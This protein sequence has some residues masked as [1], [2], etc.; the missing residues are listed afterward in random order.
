MKNIII[1]N[2]RVLGKQE[3]TFL[4]AI[5]MGKDIVLS[6]EDQFKFTRKFGKSDF[7]NKN[8]IANY[9]H[10]DP[11]V[12]IELLGPD[13]AKGGMGAGLSFQGFEHC[14]NVYR[15][16]YKHKKI[17]DLFCKVG[18]PGLMK[19]ITLNLSD[20]LAGKSKPRHSWA[21][22]GMLGSFSFGYSI[23][24][25]S[26]IDIPVE[27]IKISDAVN[28]DDISWFEYFIDES[29]KTPKRGLKGAIDELEMNLNNKKLKMQPPTSIQSNDGLD[30]KL[31]LSH[32]KRFGN[33][34][35]EVYKF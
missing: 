16:L 17:V 3:T 13:L 2:F 4:L 18:K 21:Q 35:K 23:D 1:K 8:M 30:P 27:Q 20:E 19:M 24:S 15:L 12:F 7:N 32:R 34:L 11:D 14:A 33:S 29:K 22:S 31:D 5:L 26:Y 6:K 9:K 28:M 25:L 10:L